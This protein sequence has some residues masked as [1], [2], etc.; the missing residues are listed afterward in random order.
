MLECIAGIVVWTVLALIVLEFI[1]WFLA[2]V[3]ET[4]VP[5]RIFQLLMFL[6][7]FIAVVG[8]VMCIVGEGPLM[9]LPWRRLG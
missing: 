3:L 9:P 1:K 8:L 6:V 2:K 4:E 7:A 5:A